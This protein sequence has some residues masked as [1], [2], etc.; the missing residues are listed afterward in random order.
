MKHEIPHHQSGNSVLIYI[1]QPK[2]AGTSVRSL[3][4]KHFGQENCFLIRFSLQD[5]NKFMDLSQEEKDHFDCIA[6][7][8][9]YGIHEHLSR[10]CIYV[11][12]MREPLDRVISHFSF[13]KEFPEPRAAAEGRGMNDKAYTLAKHLQYYEEAMLEE[14]DMN[15]LPYSHLCDMHKYDDVHGA[16]NGYW[17]R[18]PKV[19]SIAELK[20]KLRE[21]FV[22]VGHYERLDDFLFVF[23]RMIGG[24]LYYP[25]P[26]KVSRH[27]LKTKN[28]DPDQ[29]GQIQDLTVLEARLH[30]YAME[31]FQEQWDQLS[32]LE[33][34]HAG[35]YRFLRKG[36]Y[37]IYK[38]F[39]KTLHQVWFG[40]LIRVKNRLQ[41]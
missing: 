7:H 33:K 41:K 20:A 11:T 21:Q 22:L 28:L 14:N 40:L 23:C 12:L 9:L 31:M 15:M 37:L 17:G 34:I 1:H 19:P 30:N 35:Y 10:P 4:L 3:L 2:T 24:R 6:G 29:S 18:S 25:T 16:G 38:H 5:L 26:G 36:Q 27:R 8:G 39:Y 32:M 13:R